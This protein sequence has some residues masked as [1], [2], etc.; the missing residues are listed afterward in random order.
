MDRD[1]KRHLRDHIAR[2][3]DISH[4]RMT[5]DEALTLSRFV[6]QY[7]VRY[8]GTSLPPR[9]TTH[10]GWG[11]DGR[12]IV[13]ETYADSFPTDRVGIQQTYEY[14]DDDGVHRS[15]VTDITDGRGVLNWLRDRR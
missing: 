2:H 4:V 7:D 3:L 6:E 9:T 14:S 11:S 15:T 8:R 10:S 12:Y 13:T 1:E 5:D